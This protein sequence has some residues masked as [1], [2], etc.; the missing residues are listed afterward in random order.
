MS[1]SEL[2]QPAPTVSLVLPCFTEAKN[3]PDEF[4]KIP[5]IVT[6]ALSHEHRSVHG[7]SNFNAQRDGLR[8]L[9]CIFQERFSRTPARLRTTTT[10]T[11]R[12]AVRLAQ[13]ADPTPPAQDPTANPASHD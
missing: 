11:D 2:L 7:G 4:A 5:S 12:M 8:V 3:L 10:L 9:H 1:S 6:E 13:S